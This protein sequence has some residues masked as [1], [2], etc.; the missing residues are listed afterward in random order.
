MKT[1]TVQIKNVYG[2]EKIYPSCK[3][4]EF[5]AKLAGTKTL[6]KDK[7]N[8]IKEMGYTINVQQNIV[9]L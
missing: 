5:F 1:I 8:L 2:E 3:E 4:S 6:T 9:T 7:I